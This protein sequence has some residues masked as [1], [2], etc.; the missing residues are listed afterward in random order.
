L[1]IGRRNIDRSL[2]CNIDQDH[3]HQD[4]RAAASDSGYSGP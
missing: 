1:G 2:Q 3:Y 4:Q